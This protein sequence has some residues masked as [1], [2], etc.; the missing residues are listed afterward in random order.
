M[1]SAD[2]VASLKAA[3]ADILRVLSNW[4][5]PRRRSRRRRLRI[6]RRSRGG[7]ARPQALF[8]EGWGDGGAARLD[9]EKL[10]RLPELWSQIDLTGA[11][12]IVGVKRV[13]AA[14]EASIVIERRVTGA[15]LMFRR[16][17]REHLA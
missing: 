8:G 6:A 2:L 14:T 4:R 11:A 7:A 15:R 17:G 1:S 9:A 5:R 13:I 16:L 12:W 3:K 10:N